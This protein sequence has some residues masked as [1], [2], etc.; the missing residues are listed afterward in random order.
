MCA[1]P[2]VF[3]D[4]F[5]A[6]DRGDRDRRPPKPTLVA[7]P[8][9][10]RLALRARNSASPADGSSETALGFG[11][12]VHRR[13]PGLPRA[14]R[15][16]A[17]ERAGAGAGRAHSIRDRPFHGRARFPRGRTRRGPPRARRRQ[18]SRARG[19]VHTYRRAIEA[20]PRPRAR[21]ADRSRSI[22]IHPA[23]GAGFARAAARIVVAGA[24]A[25]HLV[26]AP[27]AE[28]RRGI[29]AD[30]DGALGRDRSGDPPRQRARP[31]RAAVEPRR[32]VGSA[33]RARQTTHC[34]EWLVLEEGVKGRAPAQTRLPAVLV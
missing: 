28:T 31:R 21:A 2:P 18:A 4:C 19:A 11:E 23:P 3:R 34:V 25:A 29:A 14:H 9:S 30:Y 8:L 15:D 5:R 13:G 16:S 7:A 6:A 27:R 1:A 12:G 33:P 22:G 17:A 20:P 10:G 24:A 26:A 32:N